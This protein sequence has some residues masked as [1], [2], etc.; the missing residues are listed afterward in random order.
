MGA[1]AYYISC[2][3]EFMVKFLKPQS[4]FDHEIFFMSYFWN[5]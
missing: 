3:K 2:Q 5:I 1:S 4:I